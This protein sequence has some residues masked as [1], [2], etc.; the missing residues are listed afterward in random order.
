MGYLYQYNQS[1]H[2]LVYEKYIFGIAT[3]STPGKFKLKT[4]DKK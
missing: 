2:T 3:I 4:P 1:I